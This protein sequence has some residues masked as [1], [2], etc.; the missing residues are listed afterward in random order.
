MLSEASSVSVRKILFD[1]FF[2]FSSLY[3]VGIRPPVLKEYGLNASPIYFWA[4]FGAVGLLLYIIASAG[5]IRLN[6]VSISSLSM[7][8]YLLF[9]QP[10]LRPQINAFVHL[11]MTYFFTF[12]ASI[13]IKEEPG[14]G[15]KLAKIYLYTNTILLT[16]DSIYRLGSFEKL[17]VAFLSLI[18]G[19][20]EF[21]KA[22]IGSLI[23]G[24]SNA[25]GFLAASLYVFTGYLNSKN[26]FKKIF[27][28]V[29]FFV[30]ALLSFSRAIY[31]A[32]FIILMVDILSRS[33]KRTAQ[34]V[35]WLS[36][37]FLLT[38][39]LAPEWFNNIFSDGSFQTKIYIAQRTRDFMLKWNSY[40][41]LF[42][43]G[44]G[45]AMISPEFGIGTHNLL[46]TYIVETGYI[47]FCLFLWFLWSIFKH[48]RAQFAKFFILLFTSGAS[49]V[50]HGVPYFYFMMMYLNSP[51][52]SKEAMELVKQ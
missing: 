20:L 10:L 38:F 47:G 15:E 6:R 26:G 7:L 21:Y 30:F 40:I 22:K 52:K 49:F 31:V 32:V 51:T 8:I 17:Q 24:D 2:F 3:L 35:G 23:F 5:R 48:T 13:L 14:D 43:L 16:A 34:L 18:T 4:V 45:N 36:F 19:S 50:P 12:V 28:K 25:V 27:F 37:I 39:T 11:L 44:A 41:S 42:G 33:A 46:S 9:T 29:V 1:G